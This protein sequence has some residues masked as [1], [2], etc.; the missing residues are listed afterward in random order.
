MYNKIDK[1]PDINVMDKM[2]TLN[3]DLGEGF[4]YDAY[5]M[6]YIHHAN[7][8]CGGHAGNIET[9][10][11]SVKL[12][13]KNN[14]LIGAHPSYPDLKN[15]GRVS[16]F[17]TMPI[18]GI[19]EAIVNQL[20]SIKKVAEANGVEV[21]HVKP[22]GALYNDAM[23]NHNVSQVVVD[24]VL[25]VFKTEVALMG[26]PGTVFEKEAVGSGFQY[27]S[28]GFADRQY[29]PNLTLMPRSHNGAVLH[30]EG[31]IKNQIKNFT[32][33]YI[34]F[35]NGLSVKKINVDTICVHSD[36][37]GADKIVKNVFEI[38]KEVSK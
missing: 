27:I 26:M 2:I 8:A 15:F 18:N 14:V 12:A 11:R 31:V 13:L 33:G 4:P 28:E 20:I 30:D 7:I 9:M 24:A 29:L 16:L 35:N 5:I 34:A 37:D 19:F 36:T 22:H 23:K 17:N 6:K 25:E 3:A 1:S 32:K 10:D 21:F 38:L